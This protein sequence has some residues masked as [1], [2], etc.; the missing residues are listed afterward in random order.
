[1]SQHILDEVQ[2]KTL[3]EPIGCSVCNNSGYIER[4]MIIEILD[5]DQ[6]IQSLIQSKSNA[7]EIHKYIKE[8]NIHLL[9]D[10]GYIKVLK[11]ITTFSEIDR[12][13]N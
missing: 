13:V 4:E 2:T 5:I 9:R 1:M 3:Y 10:D 11:G 6:E 7:M 8:R 12:V